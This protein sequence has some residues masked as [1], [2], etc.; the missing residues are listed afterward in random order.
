MD[1]HCNKCNVKLVLKDNWRESNAKNYLYRCTPC[2]IS[3]QYKKNK[4]NPDRVYEYS[5]NYRYSRNKDQ[6]KKYLDYQ[7]KFYYNNKD[8]FYY[9]YLIDN[10]VGQTEVPYYRRNQHKYLGKDVS[11]FRILAKLDTRD[12]ALELEAL[13]HDL[14]YEGRHTGGQYPRT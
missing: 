12:E 8:G 14:G 6:Q 13:L 2:C 5:K 11:T 3:Y 7:K 4:E 1:K 9:V 10:Y